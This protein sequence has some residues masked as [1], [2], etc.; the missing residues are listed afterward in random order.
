MR[1]RISL[2]LAFFLLAF[3]TIPTLA[4]TTY[5]YVAVDSGN[6]YLISADGKTKLTLAKSSD[7]I[8]WDSITVSP[9]GAIIAVSNGNPESEPAQIFEINP[10]NGKTRLI[11]RSLG[12]YIPEY[13]VWLS[14]DVILIGRW[15]KNGWD[16]GVYSLNIKNGMLVVVVPLR[17]RSEF[18]YDKLIPSPSGNLLATTLDVTS[19]AWISVNDISKGTRIWQID[20]EHGMSGFSDA[21]WSTDNK[22]LFV[23]FYRDDE[24]A[25]DSPGGL[26]KFDA[27]TGK[28]RL[29]KYPKQ[30]TY[31]LWVDTV[32][33][34]IAVQRENDIVFLRTSD[35]KLIFSMALS[36]CGGVAGVFFPGGD[37]IIICGY[38]RVIETTLSGRQIKS[39]SIK[40]I[41]SS[42][43]KLS[44]DRKSLMFSGVEDDRSVW[45]YD[46]R[47]DKL[48]RLGKD[49]DAPDD[50]RVEWLPKD[51]VR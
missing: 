14:P 6:L 16:A 10:Q 51:V 41:S 15:D 50:W 26:W 45:I 32:H 30:N 13:P 5:R 7:D 4:S 9:S 8:Y 3:T 35:G 1:F 18:D 39:H 31:G 40:G 44:P 42:S 24:M 46:L 12:F 36:R 19:A 37:R 38:D 2:V 49:K 20:P 22:F 48:I 28:K 47:T 17:N 11:R 29:W 34:I 33:N 25:M 23:S 21:V 27:L 43:V